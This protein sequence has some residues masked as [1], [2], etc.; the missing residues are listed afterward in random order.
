MTARL[1]LYHASHL[2]DEGIPC[3][4]ELMNAKLVNYELARDAATTAMELHAAHG[5]YAD[6]GIER[7]FRDAQHIY[8]PAGTSDV[9]RLRLA[10][11]G[12][13]KSRSQWSAR[14]AERLRA[15]CAAL[16][17]PASYL[18]P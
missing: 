14:L 5:L 4:A 10:E 1:S 9:Q 17:A 8:A 2:L 16:R 13:G 11:V 18:R 7:Y 6:G 3:D 12:L 15:G